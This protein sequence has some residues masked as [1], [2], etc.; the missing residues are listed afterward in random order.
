ML[1]GADFLRGF[2]INRINFERPFDRLRANGD[3]GHRGDGCK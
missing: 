1:L 3:E 2:A